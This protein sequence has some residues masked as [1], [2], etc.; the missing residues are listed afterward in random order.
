[1]GISQNTI[2][3]TKRTITFA[4][5]AGLAVGAL[6]A[7][8]PAERGA[9]G[10]EDYPVQLSQIVASDPF[11][12][13]VEEEG[14]YYMYSTG[15]GGKVFSR[16]SK[17][18]EHWSRPFVVM[19]FAPTHWASPRAASWAAEVHPYKGKYY[20]FTT[21]H[22]S[23]LL[24]DNPLSGPVPHRATQIYVSD[25][26]SGPFEDFSGGKP[27]TPWEWASLD[28]T[29]FIEDGVP[30]MVFCHEWLQVIDGTM[31][32]VRLT[33]DLSAAAGSPFTLFKASDAAWAGE[34]KTSESGTPYRSYVT[35][36]AYFFRTGSGRLGM[37]WSTW[38]GGEYCLTAAYSVS[39][40]LCG[41][42]EQLDEP[43]FSRNGGHGMLFRSFDGK[44]YLCMHWE[45]RSAQRPARRPIIAPV[46]LSG[47]SLKVLWAD[48]IPYDNLSEK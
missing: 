12:L 47:D 4:L 45:D 25:S 7:Q 41:P 10:D 9:R 32:A 6:F 30:Y 14:V 2:P 37:I 42:W 26:P 34:R 21:S 33:D 28:G 8:S 38:G 23:D 48:S 29:L 24:E 19:E 18:L 22:T 1:M 17:D 16:K 3:M 13:P 46:D 40:R 27:Q 36:G 43:L 11:I 15:G 39:G 31:E 35:D 20:L 44:D 5:A